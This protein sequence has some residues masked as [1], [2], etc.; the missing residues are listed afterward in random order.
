MTAEAPPQNI[1][2]IGGVPGELVEGV[3]DVAELLELAVHRSQ[4]REESI[5]Q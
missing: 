5:A 2:E 4:W 3:V 1:A